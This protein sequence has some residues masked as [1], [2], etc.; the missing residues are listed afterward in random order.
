MRKTSRKVKKKPAMLKPVPHALLA[1][2]AIAVATSAFLILEL[3]HANLQISAKVVNSIVVTGTSANLTSGISQ[4]KTSQASGALRL[5]PAF[6]VNGSLIVPN[7]SFADSPVVI[8]Q[9]PPGN[10]LTGINKPLNST[11]LAVINKAPD[12]FFEKGGEMYL[13]ETLTN[14]MNPSMRKVPEMFTVNGKPSVIYFGSITD[15]FSG[16]NR[17]AMALALS[18]FGSFSGLFKGYSAIQY[19]DFPTIYWAPAHYKASNVVLGAFYTSKYISFIAVEDQSPITGNFTLNPFNITQ[20]RI[21][22]TGNAVYMSAFQFLR[23]VGNATVPFIGVPYMIWGYFL[24]FGADAID[25]GNSMSNSYGLPVT[26]TTNEQVLQQLS[27]PGNQFAWTEYAAADIYVA[28]VCGSIRDAA[29]VC[30]LPAI[31]GIEAQGF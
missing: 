25:F 2:A 1:M 24:Q 30:S 13:N 28:M 12:S 10:R 31:K 21:N 26:N 3:T 20:L 7:A 15:A 11:E 4:N 9:Q 18:R 6:N 17:W 5:P 14:Y 23:S 27:H 8:E 19:G 29:P 22:S 16:E